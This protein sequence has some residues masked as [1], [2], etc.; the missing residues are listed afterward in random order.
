M[1]I[2]RSGV[3]ASSVMVST[4]HPLA[5]RTA[6]DILRNG[7]NA[8]D[9]A[10]AANAALGVLLPDQCGLGGD[11]FALVY[12][13]AQ[14]DQ[15]IIGLNGS[16][17]APRRAT[18]SEFEGRGICSMPQIG[19]LSI[20]VPGVV[21][22]WGE[23]SLKWGKL[24]WNDLLQPAIHLAERG[25]VVNAPLSKT[26]EV[27][28][29]I[30]A[31]SIAAMRVFMPG[32]KAL[33]PGQKLVQGNMA[34]LLRELGTRG[35]RSFYEGEIAEKMAAE[36]EALDGLLRK[37][38][39]ACHQ[40]EWV[41]PISAKY[42]GRA[43][44]TLPPNSAGL[45]L[46][47]ILKQLDQISLDGIGY[48]SADY[49]RLCADAVCCAVAACQPWLADPRFRGNRWRYLLDKNFSREPVDQFSTMPHLIG[50]T[51]ALCVVDGDGM[52]I[53][54]IESI[55]HD[56]GSGV[57]VDPLGIFLQ[58][59]GAS[60]TLDPEHP[61]CLAPT[62][63][64][65]HT[66]TPVLVCDQGDLYMVLG[67]RGGAG[68]PQ[69]LT[70]ILSAVIDYGLDVQEAVSGPRWVYGG[71]TSTRQANGLV[72]EGLIQ[73]GVYEELKKGD[74]PVQWTDDLSVG[75]MGC[76]QVVLVDKVSQLLIG[77]ADPRGGGLAEG[78]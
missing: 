68:Q 58:N 50:D 28:A 33:Q 54:L 45:I 4:P 11:L 77:G 1:T 48:Q 49:I 52:G 57:Y 34:E 3:T 70:Q 22:A 41:Q 14:K 51:I 69:T 19:P 53:S 72:L 31:N 16:G 64:P 35:Y 66:L 62:K 24:P 8:V 5:T 10:I 13:P 44:Y 32:G 20:T 27:S 75:W 55:Y 21:D 29:A 12:D 30:L 15:R 76:A 38:D 18:L 2:I 60:F 59:R 43:V 17:G 7:G 78:F 25:F 42:R 47:A 39:L 61:N 73:G 71:T 26:I 36:I 40:S 56:F 46:L 9:A 65:I 23:M 67:T 74:I 6:L 63:R 37:D